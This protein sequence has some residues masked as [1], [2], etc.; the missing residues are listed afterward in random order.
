MN[1]ISP[2]LVQ[3]ALNV[4]PSDSGRLPYDEWIRV[5]MATH[6]ALGAEALPV[7]EGWTDARPGELETKLRSF[8]RSG[9]VGPG[10]LFHMARSYG[11]Q[12]PAGATL[13]GARPRP[14]APRLPELEQ[15]PGPDWEAHATVAIAE[16]ADYLQTGAGP[17][18]AAVWRYLERHRG[19]TLAT[20]RTAALGYNPTWRQFGAY[21][22]APG[23][24]IP[25]LIAGEFWAINV[26]TS[27]AA[28]QA[29]Q[30]RGRELG[31]YVAMSGSRKGALYRADAL[32]TAHTAVICEGE[33]DALLL[34]QHLPAGVAAVA[35][36]G[37]TQSP[38]LRWSTLLSGMRRVLLAL[39]G[40]AAGQS[41]AQ[42][43]RDALPF[44]E[45]MPLPSANDITDYWRAGG[46]LVAWL[47]DYGIGDG[48]G[49]EAP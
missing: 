17:E 21:W 31:K 46:D 32:D 25:V 10:T 14:T 7:L 48:I 30:R 11:W 12:P 35:I 38:G 43:W 42:R 34:S 33:F 5:L 13:P 27:K 36:G 44:A 28:R 20:I 3:D 15:P 18:A 4:I 8:T 39:D 19:L 47:A 29:A 6:A 26:R 16:C 1:E 45:L 24:T 9:A 41:G 22:L 49:E 37:A 2:Q 23:I 40:D